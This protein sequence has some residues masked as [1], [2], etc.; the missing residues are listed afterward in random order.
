MSTHPH[1]PQHLMPFHVLTF[2]AKDWVKATKL[3]QLT[4]E[5]K[6]NVTEPYSTSKAGNVLDGIKAQ[7]FRRDGVISVHLGMNYT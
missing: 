1:F 2:Q 6:G 7:R 3:A 4:A 5:G